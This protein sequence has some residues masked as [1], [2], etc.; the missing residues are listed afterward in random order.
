V[1][2][3]LASR[4]DPEARDMVSAWSDSN[5]VL[6]SAEDLCSPGWSFRP[7]APAESVAVMDG[8]RVRVSELR[9]V[10][11]RRPAVLAEEL[12]RIAPADR[13][14]VAAETN[15]FLV[16]WLSSLPCLVVNR[17]TPTSLCGPAWGEL[18]WRSAAARVGVDWADAEETGDMHEVM[19]CGRRLL[20]SNSIEEETAVRALAR[21]AGVGLLGVSFRNGRVCGASAAPALTISEVRDCLLSYLLEG[22]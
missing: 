11:T 9:A 7:A 4:F 10:L 19:L 5:A 14:Y 18:Y 15:A 21:T 12:M 3:V 20:F 13:S 16:A 6:L 1:I 2:A 17:P 8:Q 22:A